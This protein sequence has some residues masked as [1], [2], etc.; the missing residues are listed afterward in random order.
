MTR[1]GLL[2][3]AGELAADDE[4]RSLIPREGFLPGRVVTAAGHRALKAAR[5]LGAPAPASIWPS[6]CDSATP[7]TS[8][9]TRILHLAACGTDYSGKVLRWNLPEHFALVRHAASERRAISEEEVRRY[10]V[11][12]LDDEPGTLAHLR[13]PSTAP[14]SRSIATTRWRLRT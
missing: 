8:P 1:R 6:F 7:P 3:A 12:P 11:E 5:V 13:W 14:C 2:W 4:R 9:R 10:L